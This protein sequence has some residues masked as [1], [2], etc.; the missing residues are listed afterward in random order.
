MY[1][2]T[3][4]SQQPKV[5][6]ISSILKE[7]EAPRAE[8]PPLKGC[9][10]GGRRCRDWTT[11]H[12]GWRRPLSRQPPSL[13]AVSAR[14]GVVSHRYKQGAG[15]HKISFR[16]T[17]F[18]SFAGAGGR[19]A[20]WTP[21]GVTLEVTMERMMNRCP[22]PGCSRRPSRRGEVIPE[23]AA[24]EVPGPQVSVRFCRLTCFY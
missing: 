9:Q 13:T 22:G 8:V 23:H 6:G 1:F 24:H 20:Q 11:A 16:S 15:L 19:P 14:P 2:L 4:S 10:L 12:V 3:K 7:S 18:V 5:D 21:G 17:L